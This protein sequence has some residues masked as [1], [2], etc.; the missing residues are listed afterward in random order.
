MSKIYINV[1]SKTTIL[2]KDEHL[3]LLALQINELNAYHSVK[4]CIKMVGLMIFYVYNYHR[5]IV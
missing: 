2:C 5:L 1:L 4:D 3:M